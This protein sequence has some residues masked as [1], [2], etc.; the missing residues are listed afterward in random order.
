MAKPPKKLRPIRLP[1]P[2]MR[3]VLGSAG[4]EGEKAY[5]AAVAT[6]Q[7]TWL[8]Q[9]L[10]QL[11]QLAELVG[12]SVADVVGN[13]PLM[14]LAEKTYGLGE[15]EQT[16]KCGRPESW[17]DEALFHLWAFVEVSKS[18]HKQKVSES[19]HAYARRFDVG[20]IS[21]E[22]LNAVYYSQALKKSHLV[23]LCKNALEDPEKRLRDDFSKEK[24]L[25]LIRELADRVGKYTSKNL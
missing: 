20:G 4:T 14:T 23:A 5:K 7:V 13:K 8:K 24:R 2:P 25:K 6:Y 9:Y 1:Q 18:G 19:L 12:I 10:E 3:T 21:H 17:S 11:S 15:S 16:K 22:S